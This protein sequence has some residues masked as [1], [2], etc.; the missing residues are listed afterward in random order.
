MSDIVERLRNTYNDKLAA[1]DEIERLRGA[2]AARDK[3]WTGQ[4]ASAHAFN[5]RMQAERDAAHS[6]LREVLDD[7]EQ[8]W[9]GPSRFLMRKIKAAINAARKEGA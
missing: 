7:Y 5:E 2:I 6:L 9:P 3:F 8:D 4:L 1:A